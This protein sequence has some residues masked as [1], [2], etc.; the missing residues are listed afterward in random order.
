MKFQ[1]LLL[2]LLT[3]SSVG[4]SAELQLRSSDGIRINALHNQAADSDKAVLF[5]HMEDGS[6]NDWEFFAKRLFR[7]GFSTLAIDLRGHGAS[8]LSKGRLEREDYAAMKADVKAGVDWL[9]KKGVEDLFVIGASLG[10]NLALQVAAEDDRVDKTVLLSPGHTIQGIR[11]DGLLADYGER[12]VFIAVSAEDAYVSKTG[13]LLDSQARGEHRL[14]ILSGAGKGTVMLDRDPSLASSIQGWLNE[15][16][17]N[18]DTLDISLD[19]P[20][21]ETERMQ[22][23]GQ[24]LPG[25]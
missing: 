3:G 12:P 25:F 24:K 21:G 20:A 14:E 7:S 11:I 2:A 10:A 23:E 18:S 17:S 19:V 4:Y 15:T 22:T 1:I 6:S 9:S 16:A 5:V 13:L 8:R